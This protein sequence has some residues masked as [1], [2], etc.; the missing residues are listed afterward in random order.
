M[1]NVTKYNE[2]EL[3]EMGFDGDKVEQILA[4]QDILINGTPTIISIDTKDN[5]LLEW[6]ENSDLAPQDLEIDRFEIESYSLWIENFD[7]A[8][9]INDCHIVNNVN[10]LDSNEIERAIQ[11]L[12]ALEEKLDEIENVSCGGGNTFE[13]GGAEYDILNEDERNE[14]A[15]DYIKDSLWAF[16]PSFLAEMTDYDLLPIFELVRKNN[17]CESANEAILCLIEKFSSIEDFVYEVTSQDGYGH[18]LSHYDGNEY[19]QG[20]YFIYRTNQNENH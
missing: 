14:N 4:T 6:L 3:L 12:Y 5:N 16:T 11:L 18:Y 15:T 2:K 8:I 10:G 19:E 17:M 13:Y 7:H 1:T 20:D 9:S